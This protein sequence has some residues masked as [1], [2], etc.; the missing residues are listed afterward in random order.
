MFP[1]GVKT[2]AAT[3]LEKAKT[4]DGR[5]V[6]SKEEPKRLFVSDDNKLA[7]SFE[8]GTFACNAQHQHPIRRCIK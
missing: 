2:A 8:I 4:K 1:S 7:A 6:R 5:M 3:K